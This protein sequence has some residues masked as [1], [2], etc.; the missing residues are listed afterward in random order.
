MSDTGHTNGTVLDSPTINSNVV[1]VTMITGWPGDP[2]AIPGW[3]PGPPDPT[4]VTAGTPGAFTPSGSAVPANI[5][6]LR[7]LNIGSGPAWSEGQ[8]V[9]IGSGNVYWTGTDWATGVAPAPGG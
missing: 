2:E 1:G 3:E 6:A 7:A 9:V 5:T 8:Y 4:G